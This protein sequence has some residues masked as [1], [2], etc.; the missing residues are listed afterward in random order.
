MISVATRPKTTN[1]V[2]AVDATIAV[3]AVCVAVNGLRKSVIKEN[4]KQNGIR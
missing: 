1:T 4:R 3:A 2:T